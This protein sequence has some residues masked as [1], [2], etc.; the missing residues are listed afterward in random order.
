MNNTEGGHSQGLLR[1]QRFF[2]VPIGDRA[3]IMGRQGRVGGL[4]TI[5]RNTRKTLR[6]RDSWKYERIRK[7]G[8]FWVTF[9]FQW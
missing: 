5:S 3:A 7:T 1:P 4:V 8:N 6:L 2:Y 9:C